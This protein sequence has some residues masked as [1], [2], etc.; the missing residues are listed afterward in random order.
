M[1]AVWLCHTD[2]WSLLLILK[3][4]EVYR[5]D[6]FDLFPGTFQTVEMIPQNP[7]VWLLHCHVTDH[8]HA[9]MEATYTVLPKEGKSLP[10]L[11]MF[12]ILKGAVQSSRT[13]QRTQLYFRHPTV[14][15]DL[16]FLVVMWKREYCKFRSLLLGGKKEKNLKAWMLTISSAPCQWN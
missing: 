14:F 10:T 9:G 6:V 7:G 8:I 3:Q 5:A 16:I 15:H 4:T 13:C 1:T 2:Q 12:I 11:I